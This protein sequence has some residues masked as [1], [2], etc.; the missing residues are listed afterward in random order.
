MKLPTIICAGVLTGMSGAALACE[1]P[2]LVVI[3][4]DG[5]DGAALQTEVTAYFAAMQAYTRCVQ[6][7]LM[8]AG[9][10]AAQPIVKAVLVQR[11]NVAVAE[12]QA[13][14][15][16]YNAVSGVTPSDDGEERKRN[17]RDRE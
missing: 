17:R 10:D 15:K 13:V 1:L 12:A 8:A 14:Q 6:A 9:G 4:P 3:P 16:L 11:N 2:P 7:E 5:G